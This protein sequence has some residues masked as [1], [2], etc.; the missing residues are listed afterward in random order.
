[1]KL[2]IRTLI[3]LGALAALVFSSG[4]AA[5]LN[6][7][8]HLEPT[9]THLGT[10]FTSGNAGNTESD[11]ASIIN[12]STGTTFTSAQVFKT[13]KA[14]IAAIGSGVNDQFLVPAGWNW[15]LVKYDG[16]NGGVALF[17]LAG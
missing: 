16:P 11:I 7:G 13:N 2:S 9:D 8:F 5:T 15:L 12:G 3:P 17:S 10:S 1:M 4:H 6:F 14:D